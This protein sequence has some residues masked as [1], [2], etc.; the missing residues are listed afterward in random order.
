MK[1]LNKL[2]L[3]S[4]FIFLASVNAGLSDEED[5][6][7]FAT[8]DKCSVFLARAQEVLKNAKKAKLSRDLNFV[9][10]QNAINNPCY[11]FGMQGWSE[12]IE[13]LTNKLA[14]EMA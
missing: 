3:M 11:R 7:Y 12:N 4:L 9:L 6:V 13:D 5:S 8:K 2:I 10:L 1:T 14:E